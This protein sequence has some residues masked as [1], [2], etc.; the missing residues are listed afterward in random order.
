M[1]KEPP[2]KRVK[3]LK[4]I[5]RKTFIFY[6]VF[7]K[8]EPLRIKVIYKVDPKVMSVETE[9][10]LNQSRNDISHVGFSEVWVRKNGKTVYSDP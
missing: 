6:A 5:T 4:R 2:E 3:S 1:F 10:Q 8:N 9:R 7:Y